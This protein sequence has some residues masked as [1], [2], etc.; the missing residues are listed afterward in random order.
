MLKSRFLAVTAALMFG[1][2][3]IYQIYASLRNPISTEIVVPYE[4]TDGIS[5]IGVII[6]D[7][8]IVKSNYS[9]A[10]HF[11][12]A[13]SERVSKG[14][15]IAGI[16]ASHDQSVAAS[17]ID[18]VKAQIKSIEEIHKYN[19]LNAV[20][21]GLINSRIYASVNNI[22][23]A[24]GA[25]NY[26]T[27]YNYKSELL[28]LINRKQMATGE[29]K[30]FSQQLTALNERL[31]QLKTQLGQPIGT[32]NSEQAGYFI[33]EADGYETVL[34]TQILADISPEFLDSLS[35]SKI[36]DSSVI[37]K[38]VSDHTWYIAASVTL[39]DSMQFKQGE[40]LTIKIPLKVNSEID[41]KVDRINISAGDDRAV[42]IFSCQEMSSELSRIRTT[43]MTVI[44]NRYSG[45]KVSSKAL[46]FVNKQSTDANGSVTS[47]PVTG[48]Y[49]LSGMTAHFVPVE[50]LYSNSS[51]AI[52]RETKEDG[53]LKIYDEIIVK[54]KNL[55]D[56]KII[57]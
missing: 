51:Y 43:S 31:S 54:G 15:V 4:T 8:D 19:D 14:G 55:Y 52:C 12:I 21:L 38:I 18:A 10:M 56:G 30:D 26:S 24:S 25:G 28:T 37:G 22:I 45:L 34:N 36:Q 16:Y 39:S 35:P 17:E 2:F 13:D 41:V 53:Q 57:D 47:T 50:V 5:V 46:R 23:R 1:F 32:I 20:D 27:A 49:V 3:I 33:S 48:I 40:S 9:G 11:E 42:V 29:V 6:R 7:E 44:K